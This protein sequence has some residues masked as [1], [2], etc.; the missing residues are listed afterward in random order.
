MLETN[1][2][3]AHT[4]RLLYQIGVFLVLPVVLGDDHN[5][6]LALAAGEPILFYQLLD[7]SVQVFLGHKDDPRSRV[8]FRFERRDEEDG[9]AEGYQAELIRERSS[10]M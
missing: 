10:E 3:D 2:L 5:E 6:S 9:Q 7:H 8:R 1:D 4:A